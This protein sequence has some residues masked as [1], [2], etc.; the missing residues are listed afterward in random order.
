MKKLNFASLAILFC[1]FI[2]PFL[3]NG[4]GAEVEKVIVS[5]EL[6]LDDG[7]TFDLYGDGTIVKTPKTNFLK[8]YK[9]EVPE[10]ELEGI[11]FGIF[12]NKIIG[13]MVVLD[14]DE[15]LEG[16]GFLNKSGLLTVTVHRNGSG[17]FFPKGWF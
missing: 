17:G 14:N 15:V 1:L 7:S 4:K 8:T 3:V 9:F 10:E 16:D 2:T 5:I 12:A 6:K 11:S 13:I